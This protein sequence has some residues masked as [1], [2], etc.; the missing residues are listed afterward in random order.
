MLVLQ[1]GLKRKNYTFFYKITDLAQ[2]KQST[3]GEFRLLV[4]H[5][6]NR[7]RKEIFFIRINYC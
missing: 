4:Q 2:I 5:R 1:I 6:I 7:K 3:R